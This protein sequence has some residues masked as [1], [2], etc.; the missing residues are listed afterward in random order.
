MG[1]YTMEAA[2]LAPQRDALGYAGIRPHLVAAAFEQRRFVQQHGDCPGLLLWLRADGAIIDA[3]P[4]GPAGWEP[5][6]MRGHLCEWLED[7]PGFWK[8]VLCAGPT[9][10]PSVFTFS[11]NGSGGYA[12]QWTGRCKL[13]DGI[14]GPDGTVLA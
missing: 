3:F 1:R 14:E 5:P 13:E 6:R 9:E 7:E 10:E 11:G 12:R 2:E 8:A 4:F